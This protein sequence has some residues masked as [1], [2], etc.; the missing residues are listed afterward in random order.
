MKECK[1]RRI[2][3]EV[4]SK[5]GPGWISRVW[6]NLGW[7]VEWINGAVHIN[8]AETPTG[9]Y[10]W[11]MIGQ[12]GSGTGHID[13]FAGP[14]QYADPVM[15]ALAASIMAKERIARVWQPIIDSVNK[16][17][18]ETTA[19]FIPSKREKIIAEIKKVLER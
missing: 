3:K 8:Y 10:F 7:H 2:A 4:K 12:P 19:K 11:F 14:E 1:A 18:D 5:L 9:D 17:F 16:V 13:F 6:E 15:A